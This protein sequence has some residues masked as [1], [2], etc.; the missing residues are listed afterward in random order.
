VNN[1]INYGDLFCRAIVAVAL[2]LLIVLG[3]IDQTRRALPPPTP[4]P[5]QAQAQ[6]QPVEPA[7]VTLLEQEQNYGKYT[8]RVYRNKAENMST[9]QIFKG[10]KLVH[11]D[12]NVRFHLGHS[13]DAEQYNHLIPI[14]RDI[15]GRG[16][17]NLVVATYSGGAHCCI[18][19]SVFEIGKVFREVDFIVGMHDFSSHFEKRE[20]EQGLLFI[21]S[22]F[23]FAYWKTSFAQSPAESV[24]LRFCKGKYRLA[25]DLMHK[26]APSKE[27]LQQMAAKIR[28]VNVESIDD[29]PP[30]L[31][32]DM[33]DLIYTGNAASAWKLFDMAWP[34]GIKGK[35]K[36]LAEFKEQLAS[37][38][39]WDQ[40]KLIIDGKPV[41]RQ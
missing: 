21:S 1:H 29:L 6:P 5:V 10:K 9:L 3:V 14:G 22:D 20:G 15:T 39:Y 11:S 16:I 34:K 13:P 18:G 30:Q 35:K 41:C 37:G 36:F 32:G 40:V 26:P 8:V 4:P 25:D 27:K 28:E 23:P 17:P 38:Q 7:S 12:E 19:Y 24:I 31:W 2:G 33:L